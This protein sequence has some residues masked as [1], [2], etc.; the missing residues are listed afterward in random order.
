LSPAKARARK[1]PSAA[2]P[3]GR[4]G[5]EPDLDLLRQLS[6]A[7][8]VSGDEGA[9]RKIVLEAIRPHVDE[10]RVD[11]LGSIL[12]VKR[13]KGR[14]APLKVLLAAHLDEVGLMIM[15]HD[16]DGSLRFEV[17]GGIAD[18]VLLGKAVLV[19]PKRLPGVI[20]AAPV[21]LL[22]SDRQATVIH[23]HQMRID[24]GAGSA[25]AARKQ[26]AVGERAGFAT[27]FSLAGGTLRGKA[28]DDRLGCATLISLL[29]GGPYPVVLHA[30]FTV[31]EEVGLRGAHVAGYAAEPDA[32]FALDCSPAL[33]LPDSRGRE[34][35]QYNTRLGLGPVLYVSDGRTIS[36]R[37]LVDHLVR[38]AQAAGLPHQLRQPGGG[39]TDAG[40]IQQTRG[41]VPVVSVSVPARYLHGPVAMAR[42]DDWRST[43]RLVALALEQFGPGVLKPPART[44]R[45]AR[46]ARAKK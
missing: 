44:A 27:E 43:L 7:I 5:P 31:Q 19:G 40:A 18:T 35:T 6:N 41:G 17:V 42:L 45:A 34:N 2:R 37:R 15:D 14:R 16:S 11:A 1:A 30:A 8:G 23:A 29:R 22:N 9:V 24:I 3:A 12:A 13:A 10:V 32:A 28:L 38:T 39:G 21:H 46:V 33:D 36:D 26:V 4:P 25:D 20:G